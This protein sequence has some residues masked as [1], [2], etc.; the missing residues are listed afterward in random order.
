MAA[1]GEVELSSGRGQGRLS[2]H[3]CALLMAGEK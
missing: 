1:G 2:E 3:T